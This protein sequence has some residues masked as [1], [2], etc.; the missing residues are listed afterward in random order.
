MQTAN[1]SEA[2]A[3]LKF[4]FWQ[5]RWTCLLIVFVWVAVSVSFLLRVPLGL[6]DSI[7]LL[8]LIQ[9]AGIT[10]VL[11]ISCLSFGHDL[12][13]ANPRSPFPRQ[14]LVVPASQRLLGLPVALLALIL[15]AASTA[16]WSGLQVLVGSSEI[17]EATIWANTPW[18]VPCMTLV[19]LGGFTQV[20]CWYPVQKAHQRA[21]IAMIGMIIFAAILVVA[22]VVLSQVAG[23]CA[24]SIL[25]AT[26]VYLAYR[27]ID[28][29]RAEEGPWFKAQRHVSTVRSASKTNRD[30]LASTRSFQSPGEALRW[31]DWQRVGIYVTGLILLMMVCLMPV[32]L[33]LHHYAVFLV[34]TMFAP[35]YIS[36]QSTT[37]GRF[38]LWDKSMRIPTYLAILP[39][40]NGQLLRQRY[41]MIAKV[42]AV[43]WG[44][45]I[46]CSV[47]WLAFPQNREQLEKL[48][49]LLNGYSGNSGGGWRIV[50]FVVV[51]SLVVTWCN[52]VSGIWLTMT[53]R[54]WPEFVTVVA[55]SLLFVASTIWAI[56]KISN[57]TDPEAVETILRG[58][59]RN[60]ISAA[61]MLVA[62]KIVVGATAAWLAY[63]KQ[64][65][66]G[67]S[68]AMIAIG[69]SL[70]ASILLGFAR[71]SLPDQ[72]LATPTIAIVIALLLPLANPFLSALALEAN[73]YP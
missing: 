22:V 46:L 8:L 73:R 44:L 4:L 3:I 67:R 42:V 52:A 10:S 57:A 26:N 60:V 16:S 5:Y 55:L 48:L 45:G 40:S 47:V 11:S 32:W 21:V 6:P 18:L 35:F 19:A 9:A 71:F 70:G 43:T 31:R 24:I 25:A 27:T 20:A 37:L 58:W 15:F 29:V 7:H 38:G 1:L 64:V 56:T 68:I 17:P 39:I 69:Y 14:W 72:W 2:K 23:A 51:A 63:R 66:S 61:S 62:A 53:G 12:D 34:M 65:F 49:G 33:R 54:K 13:L 41:W 28:W 36:T 59:S 50:L 30:T